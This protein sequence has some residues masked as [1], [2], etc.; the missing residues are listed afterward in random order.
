M[1]GMTIPVTSLSARENNLEVQNPGK[2]GNQIF[3]S[4][5]SPLLYIVQRIHDTTA[6]VRNDTYVAVYWRGRGTGF[7]ITFWGTIEANI[8]STPPYGR[9]SQ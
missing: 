2:V 8:P 9:T 4:R 5:P 6:W 7:A 1:E 3:P